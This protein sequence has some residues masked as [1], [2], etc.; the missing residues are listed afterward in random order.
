MFSSL[1][2]DEISA[3]GEELHTIGNEYRDEAAGKLTANNLGFLIHEPGRHKINI[4]FGA[5]EC[6]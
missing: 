6:V 3:K 2:P 5:A 1:L 4:F